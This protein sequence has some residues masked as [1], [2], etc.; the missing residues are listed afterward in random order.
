[1]EKV[2]QVSKRI[3]TFDLMRGWFLLA[4]T[5]NHI[6]FFPNGL[7]WISGRGGLYVTTAEGFFLVSGIVL[8]VVRGRKLID[9]P[10]R[11]VAGILLK[12]GAQ[13]YVAAIVLTLLFTLLTWVFFEQT[14][15]VKPGFLPST[16]PFWELIW[17]TLTF[18]YIYG[19]ADFLRLYALFLGASVAVF[20]LL[21]R[22][23]WPIVI[24]ASLL[25]WSFFPGD[26]SVSYEMQEKLMPLSWQLLFFVGTTI[27]FYWPQLTDWW[28]KQRASW[29]RAT[30]IALL[31]IGGTTLIYNVLIMLSTMGYNMEWA[32]IYNGLQS[33][34][35]VRFFDKEQLPLTRIALFLTWFWMFFYLFKR[36]EKPIVRF[37]GWL[38]LPFGQNSLYVYI[39]HA[40]AV[41]FIHIIW[42]PGNIVT[43][44]AITIGA[45]LLIR[46]L[47]HYRV[48]MKIIPR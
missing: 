2:R 7:G 18:D 5:I 8:G 35:Y 31:V 20:W 48:L 12:R 36:F 11:Q 3:L 30:I 42:R 29:R 32:G 1:M 46:L 26:P 44:F 33:E 34:L 6:A 39:M 45:I 19:W 15:G 17:R 27:G 21:R 22:G 10:F 37:V 41:Y 9:K 4:I 25:V 40:F 38:L 24:M 43:N 13:L 23:V 16:T 28:H 47:I 14:T